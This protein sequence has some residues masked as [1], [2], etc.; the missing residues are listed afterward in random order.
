MPSFLFVCAL[1]S[2][3][4][5]LQPFSA[6]RPPPTP[7]NAATREANSV[8]AARRAKLA[9]QIDSPILLWGFTG[10]EES[11][12]AYIFAQ[13]DNFYY[14]TGHNEEAAGLIILPAARS[15]AGT[16]PAT[17]W[18]GPQEMLFL[19][20]KNPAKEKWNGLRMSPSDPGI[21]ARTG[22][23]SVLPFPEMRATLEKLA[24]LYP[25]IYTILPYEK[26]NGGYPHE[27]E[28][29]DW[30][31]TSVP[32]TKLKDIRLQHR[33][34]CARSNRP[35]KLRSSRKPS[36]FRWMRSSPPCA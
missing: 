31:H 7:R 30:I 9:A 27:K 10:R 8:Y 6:P 33:A 12:Q 25:T 18:D 23:A 1:S 3:Q 22:F 26:E 32:Q 21:Q 24:K 17:T 4:L 5:S 11:A 14:L 29:V 16:V 34:I 13:E 2:Q 19:P 28:V 35:A 20:P 36:S 15:G